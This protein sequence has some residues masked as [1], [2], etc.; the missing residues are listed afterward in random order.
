MIQ[1]L[2]Q[3]L[4]IVDFQLLMSGI[5]GL[6]LDMFLFLGIPLLLL[7]LFVFSQQQAADWFATGVRME[8][9]GATDSAECCY[10]L[11]LTADSLFFPARLNRA[12]IRLGRQKLT[13]AR[14]DYLFLTRQDSLLAEAWG[15][16]G[17]ISLTEKKYEQARVY[18][19]NCQRLSPGEL[20]CRKQL[21][22]CAY[23]TGNYQRAI[24]LLKSLSPAETE[25]ASVYYLRALCYRQAGFS[26]AAL[27]DLATTVRLQPGHTQ[28]YRE[29]IDLLLLKNDFQ[30]VCHDISALIQ[31][32]DPEANTLKKKFCP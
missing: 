15:G 3:N 28:A 27:D 14:Q 12:R 29:R 10:T 17:N 23:F 30:A 20:S 24:H 19:E 4:I 21:A 31:H 5:F 18:L 11:C 1:I 32:N 7:P 9:A 25:D 13:E 8:Y 16:L 2:Q 26:E 6:S 22:Y